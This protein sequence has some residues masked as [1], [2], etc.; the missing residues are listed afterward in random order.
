[1]EI[2]LDSHPEFEK[3][4]EGHRAHRLTQ[5][6]AQKRNDLLL[7]LAAEDESSN[8]KIRRS[9]DKLREAAA[10]LTDAA[11]ALKTAEKNHARALS[12]V[13][14]PREQFVGAVEGHKIRR[15]RIL[16]NLLAATPAVAAF[17]KEVRAEIVELDSR[18]P[19]VVTHHPHGLGSQTER[20][21]L[22]NSKSLGTRRTALVKLLH[23]VRTSEIE[24]I[25]DVAEIERELSR[26]YRELPQIGAPQPPAA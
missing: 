25:A 26:L 12:G 10:Q 2:S 8:A 15:G 23:H 18:E 13:A 5:Y 20:V 6:L 24:A 16:S 7:S 9:R 1:M 17:V 22:T 21:Q 11:T 4:E 14:A 3:I 19:D